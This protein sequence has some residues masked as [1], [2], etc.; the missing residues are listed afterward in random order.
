MT[1]TYSSVIIPTFVHLMCIQE[2]VCAWFT[3]EC[4]PTIVFLKICLILASTAT[5]LK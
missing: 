5:Y 1:H 3:F 2:I 4:Q